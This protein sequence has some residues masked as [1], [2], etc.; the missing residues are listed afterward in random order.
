MKWSQNSFGVFAETLNMR[1]CLI[2]S[3]VVGVL[4]LLTVSAEVPLGMRLADRHQRELILNSSNIVF[5]IA[6]KHVTI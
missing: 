4:C 1:S 2:L 3:V 5:E 6:L